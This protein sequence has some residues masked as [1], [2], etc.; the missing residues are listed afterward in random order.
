MLVSASFGA[1]LD[2]A[3]VVVTFS[4]FD[5]SLRKGYASKETLPVDKEMVMAISR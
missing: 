3:G 2:A 4:T 1:V 5:G